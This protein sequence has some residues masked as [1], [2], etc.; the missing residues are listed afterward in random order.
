MVEIVREQ[1]L[2]ESG[3]RYWTRTSDLTDVNLSTCHLSVA[4]VPDVPPLPHES[5]RVS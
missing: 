2:V 3:G 4:D 1:V 5:V